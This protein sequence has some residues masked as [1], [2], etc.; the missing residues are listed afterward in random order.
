MAIMIDAAGNEGAAVALMWTHDAAT[1]LNT[2]ESA[3]VVNVASTPA[4]FSAAY[5]CS[6]WQRRT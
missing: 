3:A 1:P 6:R 5:R 4:V 2:S